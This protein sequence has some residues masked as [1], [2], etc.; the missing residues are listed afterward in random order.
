MKIFKLTALLLGMGVLASANAQVNLDTVK[1]PE[2]YMRSSIYTVLLKSK[3][4]DK[5]FDE[6]C[7]KE[8]TGASLIKDLAGT[9][10][11]RDAKNTET[12]PMSALPAKAF[13]EIAIPDQ[14]NDFNQEV[15][16]VNFEEILP[17]L[18]DDD[19][20]IAT[21]AK[22]K[23]AFG[24]FAAGMAKS[25][26]GL[27]AEGNTSNDAVNQYAQSVIN[28]FA[29]EKNVA[30]NFIA[31]WFDYNQTPDK[32]DLNFL[33]QMGNYDATDEEKDQATLNNTRTDLGAARGLQLINN[34]YLIGVNL[35]FRSNAAIV[36]EGEKVASTFLGN[37]AGQLLSAA[38]SAAA[39][40]GFS[41]EAVTYLFK[42][43]WDKPIEISFYEKI[44]S[45]KASLEE[46]IASGLCKLEYL[47]QEKAK[48]RVR[49]SITNTKPLSDLV[50]EATERAID[51]AIAKLQ[52]KYDVF[53]TSFPIEEV[54]GNGNV[55]ARIG[56]KEGISKGDEYDIVHEVY[57]P[58]TNMLEWKKVGS[59]KAVD[60]Q[61]WDNRAGAAEQA[62]E[63]TEGENVDEE[64]A[65]KS[66][67]ALGKTTFAGAKKGQQFAG[68]Y[69]RLKKKK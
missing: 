29:V 51:S 20:A 13:L 10:A 5:H 54:D 32:W 59:V 45:Q 64:A 30:P 43:V 19:K 44:Y 21:A 38:A 46:L 57:N 61:I 7:A 34:T 23:S 50:K 16:I 3:E 62:K 40:D 37:D 4:Q 2:K 36:A 8:S 18:T 6:E 66:A 24:S 58:K 60:K 68:H 39:G 33:D 25:A 67:V 41:V 31:K 28:H 47:G 49:M 35:R 53:R 55:Y 1:G 56:M 12:G 42:L 27:N 26:V 17:K 65:D 9:N 22:K 52:V 11:K 14:F 69:L 63:A 15:R 48:A